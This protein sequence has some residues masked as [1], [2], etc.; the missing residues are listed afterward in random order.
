[1]YCPRSRRSVAANQR[2][3][4][5]MRRH[6]TLPGALVAIATLVALLLPF[7]APSVTTATTTGTWS[8]TGSMHVAR[9]GHTATLLPGGKVLV[10]GGFDAGGN[11]LAGAELYDPAAGTWDTTGSM[12]TARVGHSATL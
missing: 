7:A 11:P 8:A 2:M 10:A 9:Y 5:T 4:V 6:R 12:G 1:M 3:E